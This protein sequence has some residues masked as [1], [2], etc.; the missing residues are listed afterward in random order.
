[1]SDQKVPTTPDYS[2]YIQAY[3]GIAAHAAQNGTDALN[4]AKGQVANNSDLTNQVTKGLVDT[5]TSFSDAAK[6]Q[7]AKSG[8]IENEG[9]SRL[10]DQYN[11]YTD[12]ARKA[13]DMGAAGAGAAQASDAARNASMSELESY[14]VNPGAVRFGGLDAAQRLQ[15]A[16][17]R[18][19]AENV[20]GRTDDALADQT[21]QELLG[22]GNT[23]AGQSAT[24]AGVGGSLNTGAVNT[25]L[26]NTASGYQGL[27]TDLAWTGAQT[28]AV[29]GGVNT[30]NTGFNNEAAADKI[31]N[32]SSSGVGS[33]LGLGA[34]MLGKGGALGSGGALATGGA[35]AFLEDGGAVPGGA[36]PVGAS[37][38]GG[39]VT[40]DVPASGPKGAI[41]LNGGEFVIPKDVAAWEGEK[42]LQNLIMKAR[43]AKAEATA[44]PRIQAP[45]GPDPASP[46]FQ[47][48]AQAQ[49]GALPV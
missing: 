14:G 2:P 17:T 6:A 21:N 30:Q 42:S 45:G 43:K 10:E 1:M 35:L 33:L 18:V 31:S 47:Q 13:S 24:N 39:A 38:S 40:D 49:S 7:L 8:Q 4:W 28:G 16:A 36:I 5:G 23:I 34:S 19:G 48:R 9:V 12:P 46:A 25:S 29:G 37:P 15:S 41:R 44:K 32:D 22:Q 20:A 11:K 26:A 3:N 27:G